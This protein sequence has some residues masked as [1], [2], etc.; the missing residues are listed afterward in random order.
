MKQEGL[1]NP[2]RP[3]LQWVE[4]LFPDKLTK[5]SLVYIDKYPKFQTFN[6]NLSK[7]HYGCKK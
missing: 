7:S 3:T 2:Q 4:T 1:T 5:K 6:A